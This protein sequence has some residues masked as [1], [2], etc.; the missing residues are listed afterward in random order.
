MGRASLPEARWIDVDVA[1]VFPKIREGVPVGYGND[2]EDLVPH[3]FLDYD[4]AEG[5]QAA[6]LSGCKPFIEGVVHDF[7]EQMGCDADGIRKLGIHHLEPGTDYN[8]QTWHR[9]RLFPGEVLYVAVDG[10]PTEAAHG[11]DRFWF[12]KLPYAVPINGPTNY[13]VSHG[14]LEVVSGAA[15]QAIAMTSGVVHRA[16]GM[17]E[18]SRVVISA[19][20]HN[21][22]YAREELMNSIWDGREL[23]RKV[24]HDPYGI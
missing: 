22:A 10:Q 1:A 16:G 18:G 11:P 15:D 7:Q 24:R 12:N 6:L 19:S 3:M 9:D 14:Y 17:D 23:R 13:L 21:R 4:F 20:V 2:Y 8:S 5:P